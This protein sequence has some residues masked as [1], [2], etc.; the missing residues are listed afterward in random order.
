VSGPI[1]TFPVPRVGSSYQN[2]S[3]YETQYDRDSSHDVYS[4]FLLDGFSF[5][6][7]RGFDYIEP[8]SLLYVSM[9]AAYQATISRSGT[10]FYW[11][12]SGSGESFMIIVAVYTSTGS[13]L[14]GYVT[15]TG[16][17]IG[18]MIIPG[19][20]LASYPPGSIA[21]VHMTRQSIQLSPSPDLGG[22]IENYLEW[23]VIGTGYIQ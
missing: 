10:T 14:L 7:I 21:A 13:D 17:D 1:H 19:A 15:C 8:A 2:E 11:G 23:E 9:A 4:D 12:P 18:Y 16:E 22:Y 20:Y 5:N 6:S 3:I